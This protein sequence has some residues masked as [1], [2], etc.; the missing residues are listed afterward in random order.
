MA[1]FNVRILDR[2]VD[3][4]FAKERAFRFWRRRSGYSRCV[5][6]SVWRSPLP[7]D[8]ATHWRDPIRFGSVPALNWWRRRT[9]V[10][11]LLPAFV[12]GI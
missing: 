12:G 5:D 6:A 9:L 11:G 8:Q 2:Q 1:P 4:P 3:E 7:R 10:E